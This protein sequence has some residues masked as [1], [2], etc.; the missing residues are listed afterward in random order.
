MTAL[1]SRELG[2]LMDKLSEKNVLTCSLEAVV[3]S[4]RCHFSPQ[5][6]FRVDS[7]VVQILRCGEIL[8]ASAQLISC[9]GFISQTLPVR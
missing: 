8:P 9:F 5:D 1:S 3:Y 4:Y 7:T 6:S 2:N